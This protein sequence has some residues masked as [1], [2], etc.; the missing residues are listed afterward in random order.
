MANGTVFPAFLKAEYQADPAAFARFESDM[1]A[2]A[3]RAKSGV[4]RQLSG[5]SDTISRALSVPRNA[6][7]SLDLGIDQLRN[8][9]RELSAVAIASREVATAMRNEATANQTA[10]KARF[11]EVRAA[12]ASTRATE[13]KLAAL[14]QEIALQ[15]RIQAEL[16]QTASATQAVIAS[17]GRGTTAYRA[18]TESVR[19]MRQATTQ[20]GQQLQDIVISLGS[21]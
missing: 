17:T 15:D 2:A 4:E 14:R 16:N 21:G 7:G 8:M 11:E 5:L 1:A 9:E 19:G 10:N 20:A 3:G 18:N 6:F 12:F 13:E